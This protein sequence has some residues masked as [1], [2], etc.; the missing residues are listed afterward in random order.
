M[1]IDAARMRTESEK[2][3]GS[4]LERMLAF[5]RVGGAVSLQRQVP[6]RVRCTQPS[7]SHMVAWTVLSMVGHAS[8]TQMD[9]HAGWHQ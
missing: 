4:D 6:S 7:L 1:T 2:G 8:T 9:A 3:L 5:R